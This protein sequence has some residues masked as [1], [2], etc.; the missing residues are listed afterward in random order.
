MQD[1]R[2][3]SSSRDPLN[4]AFIASDD[5]GLS[6]PSLNFSQLSEIPN[7]GCFEIET[8]PQFAKSQDYPFAHEVRSEPT[9]G[10]RGSQK[11][12]KK[13]G[14]LTRRIRETEEE[15]EEDRANLR[16]FLMEVQSGKSEP[17]A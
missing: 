8:P 17:C 5:F 9:R 6:S 3:A 12:I 1:H 16:N 11:M 13:P 2:S 15:K 7:H 10:D 4:E 14:R